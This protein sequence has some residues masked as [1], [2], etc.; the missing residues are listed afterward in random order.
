MGHTFVL[1]SAIA[2]YFMVPCLTF[3]AHRDWAKRVRQELPSWR[4]YLGVGS[5]A[6]T[7]IVWL[8][9]AYLGFSRYAH[10]PPD[11]FS[12]IWMVANMFIS[13]LGAVGSLAL[14]GRPRLSAFAAAALMA[15]PFMGCP[16]R[17]L[18]HT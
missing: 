12:D 8:E 13:V 17:S 18:S 10:L 4:S 1:C 15:A 3:V 6:L 2:T 7:L 16:K 11:F 9:T 5:M 14:K